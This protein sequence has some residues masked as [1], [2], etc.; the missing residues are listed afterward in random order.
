MRDRD[1][2]RMR[3]LTYRLMRMAPPAPPFPEEP[4]TELKPTP[5][6]RRRPAA[7]WAA[8]AAV[9]VLV[10]IGIPA[11]LMQNDGSV[12]TTPSTPAST[13]PT[14]PGSV[15]TPS[16]APPSTSPVSDSV[17]STTMETPTTAVETTVPGT[18]APG[19]V[20]LSGL[21]WVRTDFAQQAIIGSDGR[22][23]IDHAVPAVNFKYVAWDGAQGLVLLNED[24]DLRWV[25]PDS[26]VDVP[27]DV[28]GG[29]V[30]TIHDVVV[31]DGRRVA[32][33]GSWAGEIAWV[34]IETGEEV[35]GDPNRVDY[36]EELGV[37]LGAF[38]RLVW[39]EYPENA[40]AE[41]DET[42]ALVWP[43]DLPE[44]V[45]AET[46]GT[47][48]ARIELGSEQQPWAR[49]HDFDGRRV[50]VSVEPMEPAFPPTTV[51][52][53]DLECAD[54][55]QMIDLEGADTLDLVGVLESEGPV[56]DDFDL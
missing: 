46:D 4:M 25:R 51:Y 55:T 27:V 40:D 13:P 11:F 35:E 36:F 56:L 18:T 7:I 39:I 3:E 28:L 21:E 1:T 22:R 20:D 14:S 43:F 15:T 5:P 52:V 33:L 41:R 16:T 38:D 17:P 2:N 47:E 12:V 42:G 32:A 26:E 19:L 6:P 45:V 8:V 50:V 34:D 30:G 37:R 44:L 49:L 10:A 9:A 24:G 48:L 31:V 54:C 53:I 29:E 23:V